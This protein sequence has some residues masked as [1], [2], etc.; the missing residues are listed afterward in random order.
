MNNR[1]KI[2]A[3]IYNERNK[4]V[5]LELANDIPIYHLSESN[6]DGKILKPRIPE[7]FMTRNGYEEG[8][9]PRISFSTSI[10]GALTGLSANLK[11]K[12]FYIHQIDTSY[13]KPNIRKISNKEVP[14][15]SLTDEIWV[16]NPVKLKVTGKIK[17]KEAYDKPVKYKYGKDMEAETYRW[18]YI[19]ED[20]DIIEES[21]L[22]LPDKVY[23]GSPNRIFEIKEG[24][25]LTP[26]IGIASIFIVDKKDLSHY[27]RSIPSYNIG[28]EQWDWNDEQLQSPLEYLNITHNI[29]KLDKTYYGKSSGF[30]YEIDI[31]KVK[32]KFKTFVTNDENREIIYTGKEPLKISKAIKHSIKW[33]FKFSQKDADVFGIA[34]ATNEDLSTLDT[35]E[36]LLEYMSN[37]IEYGYLT[38]R[39][40]IELEDYSDFYHQYRLQSPRQVVENRVGVCWDQVELERYIFSKYIKLPFET[41][42]IV[43]N[44][45]ERGTHTFLIYKKDGKSYYFENS[46]EKFRGIKEFNNTKDII[47]YVGA[48]VLADNPD[49]TSYETFKYNK[50][51]DGSSVQQFMDYCENK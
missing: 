6:L 48:N 3:E 23:H 1:I 43:C 17:V 45:R 26:H 44:N 30:I 37:N 38:R 8:K 28:Y 50:P 36:K 51:R 20:V 33:D 13:S 35:P 27:T 22:K 47:K 39:G 25:F 5:V 11:D 42:Y 32:D 46:Y 2:A 16:L 34:E 29:Q 4:N 40:K 31:S 12:E 14:D 9:T 21:G 7:N 10:D 49:A 19:K 24:S 18:R 15:Q 41:Y